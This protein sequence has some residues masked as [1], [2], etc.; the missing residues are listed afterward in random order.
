MLPKLVRD[1]IPERIES[2]GRIPKIRH[3]TPKEMDHFLI[4][5]MKEELEEFHENPCLE[6]AADMYEVFL[7]ILDHWKMDKDILESVAF[8]KREICGSFKQGYILES[9]DI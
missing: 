7:S 8:N 2:S 5:K 9:V 1:M 6:E 4:E 3:A